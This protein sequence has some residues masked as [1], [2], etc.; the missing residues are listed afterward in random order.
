MVG[1][2][3]YEVMENDIALDVEKFVTGRKKDGLDSYESGCIL[4]RNPMNLETPE[5]VLAIA[6]M[7]HC[8]FGEVKHT[9][10]TVKALKSELQ[11]EVLCTWGSP[12]KRKQALLDFADKAKIKL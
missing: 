12:E 10:E 8:E 9:D 1:Q 6:E 4:L 3:G 2:W 7:E 5:I 11:D